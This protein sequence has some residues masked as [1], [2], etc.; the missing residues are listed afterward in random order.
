LRLVGDPAD[1]EAQRQVLL[2]AV[3]GGVQVAPQVQDVAALGHDHAQGDAGLAFM[4]GDKRR[5]ILRATGEGRDITQTKHLATAFDRHFGQ[6]IN[7]FERAIHAYIDGI[8]GSL[9]VAGRRH[10]VLLGNGVE[11]GLGRD[12]QRGQL[13][14]VDLHEDAFGLIA[15][16]PHLGHGWHPKQRLPDA[17]GLILELAH[18]EV[19]AGQDI[20]HRIHVTALVVK[21]WAE[22]AGGK[23]GPDIPHPFSDLIPAFPH[24]GCR[25]RFQDLEL[26]DHAA[27]PGIGLYLVEEGN[28]LKFFLDRI[29][30]Q[31]LHL[32][33]RGSWP[34]CADDHLLHGELRIFGSAEMDIR[35]YSGQG[36]EDNEEQG[37]RPVGDGPLGQVDPF[38]RTSSFSSPAKRTVSPLSSF[39]TPDVTMRSPVSSSPRTKASPSV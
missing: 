18:G 35:P 23:T 20:Q 5:G 8:G 2:E 36:D 34:S 26:H 7:A 9:Q 3:H 14:V 11:D 30:H 6:G 19:R 33:S 16:K 24:L 25:R 17:F 21:K 31:T 27:G 12:P 39:W 22:D 37:E 4:A 10:L 32:V 28:F 29:G 15:V 13:G 1:L 38:H